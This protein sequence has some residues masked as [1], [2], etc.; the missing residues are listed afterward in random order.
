[1]RNYEMFA[2]DVVEALSDKKL[3]GKDFDATHQLSKDVSDYHVF[4]ESKKNTPGFA[5]VRNA[6]AERLVYANHNY[7]PEY[8]RQ[9][10]RVTEL[11]QGELW[12]QSINNY[13][14]RLQCPEVM[15]LLVESMEHL[16]QSVALKTMSKSEYENLLQKE[17]ESEE[18]AAVEEDMGDY[19][20]NAYNRILEEEGFSSDMSYESL[21]AYVTARLDDAGISRDDIVHENEENLFFADKFAKMEHESSIPDRIYGD[22]SA[23]GRIYGES[24]GQS[25][26]NGSL[27][28]EYGENQDDG[29]NFDDL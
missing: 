3:C 28:S 13:K 29:Y 25:D 27:V 23:S 8:L 14:M 7:N 22:G 20:R 17:Y 2:R 26:R 16:D 24:S 21:P 9:L 19:K 4:Y 10:Q 5:D 15:G 12:N 1:M 6:L 11:G 18:L